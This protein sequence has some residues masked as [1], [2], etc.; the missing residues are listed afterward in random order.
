[1]RSSDF[2]DIDLAVNFHKEL[3]PNLWQGDRLQP[4]VRKALMRIAHDFQVFLGIDDFDLMDITI[5]G[6]NAAYTYTATSDIDLHLVTMIPKEHEHL[7]ELFNAKKYQYND[8][9]RIKIRGVDVELYVQDAEQKH[10][11]AGVYSILH[12]KWLRKPE[13]RRADLNDAAVQEKFNAMRHRIH[14]AIT[15]DS[16][17]RVKAVWDDV[18]DMRRTGLEREGEF[19]PENLAYKILRA[20]G[21]VDKLAL[22]V[23]DIK[24]KELSLL[25]DQAREIPGIY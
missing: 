13:R 20:Q 12:N 23:H 9:H 16:Y 3:N 7:R 8:M 11:S 15:S 17:D 24:D 22:H 10:F 4:E 5:S 18:K 1:M 6:S 2:F 21:L 25:Q 14:A 19:S